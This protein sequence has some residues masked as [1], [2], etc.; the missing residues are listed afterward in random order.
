MREEENWARERQAQAAGGTIVGK[1]VC[2]L[3]GMIVTPWDTKP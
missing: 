1:G 2:L 3:M